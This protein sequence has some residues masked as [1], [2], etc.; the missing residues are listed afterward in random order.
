MKEKK[1]KHF[2]QET[3]EFLS[4]EKKGSQ[5]KPLDETIPDF[6]GLDDVNLILEKLITFQNKSY[7]KF[8]NIVIL[9]GGTGSG[10]GFV[11][12]KLLGIEGWVFDVDELKKMIMKAPKINQQVKAEFGIELSSFNQKNPD[13]V[14]KLHIMIADILQLDS[15]KKAALFAS[16]L[17]ADQTRKPNLIFDVTLRNLRKLQEL[18]V[19]GKELGYDVKNIHIVWILNHINVAIQQNNSRDRTVPE[20]ILKNT[21]VGVSQTMYDIFTMGEKLSHYM[22]G[23]IWVVPNQVKVD[24]NLVQNDKNQ[25]S[26]ENPVLKSK[27][28]NKGSYIKD[29]IYFKVKKSGQKVSIDAFSNELLGKIKNYVPQSANWEKVKN[30]LTFKK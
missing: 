28:N 16:I 13:D 11:K 2:I 17:T 18:S 3:T 26:S 6:S 4:N 15:K 20:E 14:A 30:F 5:K 1:L 9:A 7:P 8:G 10:K 22:D 21:H 19:F 12:D 27:S 29:A 24:S 23:D 25:P